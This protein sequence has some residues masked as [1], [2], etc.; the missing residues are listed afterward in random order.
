MSLKTCT[1]VLAMMAG[2]AF[3]APSK[4]CST[5][6]PQTCEE[7][8]N[9]TTGYPNYDLFCK[10]PA[11]EEFGWGNPYLGLVRCDT[12][13][14]PANEQQ[15]EEHNDKAESLSTCMNACTGSFEKTKRQ[16]DDYWFCHGVNFIQGELCEYI[17]SLGERT[18]EAG[19]GSH[20]YYL[21][22]L[23]GVNGSKDD[24]PRLSGLAFYQEQDA[25]KYLPPE[26]HQRFD[27]LHLDPLSLI[28][29]RGVAPPGPD[30]PDSQKDSYAWGF[31][32]HESCW[33]L[34]EQACTPRPVNLKMLWC[35]LRSVPHSAHVPF[36]GHNF[37]GLYLGARRNHSNGSH[38]VLLEGVS[39]LMIPSTYYDPFEVPELKRR[40]TQVRIKPDGAAPV[41]ENPQAI[42]P[43]S[44]TGSDPFSRLPVE[45]REMILTHVATEDTPSFRLSSRAIAATPLSQY[46]FQSRFWPG[47]DLE[48]FFDAFLLSPPERAGID[49]RELYR[50][51]KERIKYNLVGLGERN[52]LRIWK[53]TVRPLAQ[54]I[55]EIAK[56]SELKGGSCWL[57]DP[58]TVRWKSV[59]ASRRLDIELFGELEHRVFEAEIGL[60]S[61][62]IVAIHVSL[63]EFF[64]T[65]FI[66]GLVFETEQGQDI[67]IGYI[68]PGAEEPLLVEARLE[69]FHVA[70]DDCGFR[71]ISPYTTQHMQ[72]EYLDWV[73][74]KDDLPIQTL[75]CGNGAIRRVRA[76]FD[77]AALQAESKKSKSNQKRRPHMHTYTDRQ[78][79]TRNLHGNVIH[80]N[81]VLTSA[82]FR[83]SRLSLKHTLSLLRGW[84]VP[85]P[86]THQLPP[87]ALITALG[88]AP[89]HNAA[90]TMSVGSDVATEAR[91]SLGS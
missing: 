4:T 54:A 45:L 32:F 71:A 62:N 50:L 34:I 37:G 28:T 65:K 89:P 46:F 48:F 12:K 91:V 24:E 7:P 1:I 53:Q 21:D 60:P 26:A 63:V 52:R 66:S 90:K 86:S 2:T 29:I 33:R 88:I 13:C 85:V 44:D 83:A 76:T 17:G 58:P 27:D 40:F 35:I 81:P 61:S 82:M 56:S 9:Q 6:P 18:F 59:E 31:R 67:E 75:K 69:G 20:C 68:R 14:A 70:V 47:S 55:D 8:P 15:R 30:I 36:W 39:N 57:Q 5:P 41:N 80:H 43:S 87:L 51:S 77:L 10:C 49:W 11:K 23:D 3:A 25:T 84:L 79:E 73:G 74:N 19:S 22:G 64:N 42:A 72:S 78:A 16:N 38:F